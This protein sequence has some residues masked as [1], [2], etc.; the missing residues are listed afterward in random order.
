MVHFTPGIERRPPT[1]WSRSVMYSARMS[2]THCCELF[3]A[4]TAAFCTIDVGFE[5]DW[6]CNFCTALTTG[7]GPSV[8]PSRRPVTAQVIESDPTTR[9]R[10]RYSFNDPT[11]KF[12]PV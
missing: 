5:V 1:M 9:K 4:A 8:Y 10:S 12:L 2:A 7:A 3:S 6:L 11:E